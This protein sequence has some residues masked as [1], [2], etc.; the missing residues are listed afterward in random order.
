M[1]EWNA[2]SK[3][4]QEARKKKAQENNKVMLERLQIEEIQEVPDAYLHKVQDLSIHIPEVTDSDDEEPLFVT[5]ESEVDE[6]EYTAERNLALGLKRRLSPQSISWE[7]ESSTP[8][9]KP[10]RGY[11]KDRS[12]PASSGKNRRSSYVQIPRPR[13]DATQDQNKFV[14]APTGPKTSQI[15]QS[16]FKLLLRM[17]YTPR[18]VPIKSAASANTFKVTKW[19]EMLPVQDLVDRD[20]PIRREEISDPMFKKVQKFSK[21]NGRLVILSL[22]DGV[23]FTGEAVVQRVF[24]GVI[25]DVQ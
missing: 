17:K 6:E 13:H 1:A 25:Q 21:G 12:T 16:S 8:S 20:H 11:Q 3:E 22:V 10:S 2:L 24:G 5:G 15:R 14:S 4:E 18:P 7:D 19:P 23:E 9:R